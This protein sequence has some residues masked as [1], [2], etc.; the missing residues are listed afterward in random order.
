MAAKDITGT[1]GPEGTQR[2]AAVA[3]QKSSRGLGFLLATAAAEGFGDAVSRA[4]LP[5]LAVSVLGLGAGFV[6]V[7]NAIGIAAFVLLGVQVGAAV[8]RRGQPHSAMGAASLL[9]C[10]ALLGLAA[11]AVGGW[12]SPTML[13]AAAVLVGVA[14]VVFTTAQTVLIPAVAGR[15]GLKHAYSRLA[16][17]GQTAS[18]TAAAAAGA[19]LALL[20]MPL[21]L[22][23]AAVAYAASRLFQLG[24]P[25]S[26]RSGALGT[27]R[28]PATK[29]EPGAEREPGADRQPGNSGLAGTGA[30]GHQP[31]VRP[32]RAGREGF[33]IL[34]KS[35]ALR[36]LTLSACLTNAAAMVGNTILPVYVLRDLSLPPAAYAVLGAFGA[37]GAVLGAAAAPSISSRLGLRVSRA[38]A[39]VLSVPAI[40]LAVACTRLPGPE[41]VWLGLEFLLW[42]FLVAV[43]G[44]AGSEV[45]PGT[46]PPDRLA[47]V[48]AAQRTLTLGVMPVAALAAGLLGATAGTPPVFWLWVLL[49][50]AA[51]VP[52]VGTRSL[53]RF[54]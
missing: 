20:G 53:D 46:V 1:A 13:A 54:R 4:V 37:L 11:A 41:L 18:A 5:I 19:F 31:Q 7:L 48:G 49:A 51:A 16:I 36:A 2:S 43:A 33:A 14:D 24:L 29:R 10:L 6:G 45:L 38:G 39:A 26:V 3:Q 28:Q 34:R 25:R 27:E 8:D 12:L 50:A 9:R 23:A 21:L 15:R 40:L 42:A 35:P 47:T 32:R 30:D 22:A 44:V 17:T 52:I